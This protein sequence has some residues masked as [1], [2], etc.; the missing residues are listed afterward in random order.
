MLVS[1]DVPAVTTVSATLG[2]DDAMA[3]GGSAVKTNASANPTGVAIRYIV[4][5]TRHLR[6]TTCLDLILGTPPTWHKWTR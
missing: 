4:L 2:A 3:E 5:V 6:M 1:L